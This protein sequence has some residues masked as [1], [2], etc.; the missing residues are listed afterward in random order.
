LSQS[1]TFKSAYSTAGLTGY[2][3]QPGAAG[4]SEAFAESFANYYGGNSSYPLNGY[5]ASGP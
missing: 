3:A 1:A 5:W 2:Y 4:L